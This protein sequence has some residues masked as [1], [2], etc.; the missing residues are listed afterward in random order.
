MYL[1]VIAPILKRR[2]WLLRRRRNE[3]FP[4][5]AVSLQALSKIHLGNGKEHLLDIKG[6]HWIQIHFTQNT[7]EL[8]P[9]WWPEFHLQVD[10]FLFT[11]SCDQDVF[12]FGREVARGG[13]IALPQVL[14]GGDVIDFAR[15]N[16]WRQ[17]HLVLFCLSW[18][19]EEKLLTYCAGNATWSGICER[20]NNDDWWY[21]YVDL[22]A[23]LFSK[24][25]F[26]G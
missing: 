1:R 7:N 25:W 2:W 4:H 26:W 14:L 16:L 8:L 21:N 19:L 17:L 11:I 13:I 20:G 22:S 23:T 10:D 6:R 3:V 9:E 15:I 12:S 24:W 5:L 18:R